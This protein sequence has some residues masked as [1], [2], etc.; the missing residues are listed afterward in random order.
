M[1]LDEALQVTRGHEQAALFLVDYIAYCHL[2]DD[3]I[4]KD[5]PVTDVRLVQESLA[6]IGHFALNSWVQT[7]MYRLYPLMVSGFNAWLDANEM[8]WSQD[9]KIRLSS[10]TV[11]GIYHEIVYVVAYLVGG[12][13]HMRVISK[14]R[15]YDYDQKKG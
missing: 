10:D 14:Q 4:D 12:F 7:N 1:K 13:E 3:V 6:L 8:E 2:L 11:K 15:S 5:K 9:E